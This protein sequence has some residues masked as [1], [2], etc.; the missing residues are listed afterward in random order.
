M[1]RNGFFSL[2]GTAI[3][4][5]SRRMK[6][7]SSL[8]LIGPPKM[9]APAWS[10]MVGGSG[11]PKRGRRTSS[12]WPS[13]CKAWPTRP[14]VECSW[15]R[16]I[17]IGCPMIAQVSRKR[18]AIAPARIP[19]AFAGIQAAPAMLLRVARGPARRYA[20]I[21]DA[22]Q[23]RMRRKAHER[24]REPVAEAGDDHAAAAHEAVDS[25]RAP[26]ARPAASGIR[27]APPVAQPGARLEFGR[28]RPRTERGHPMPRPA[29]SRCSASLNDST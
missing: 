13:C 22:Q 27:S 25:R 28:H 26:R 10:R 6:S 12:G 14:G 29:S 19:I 20:P 4:S 23:Q 7:S 1:P 24:R 9:T 2:S 5:I 18:I 8:A 16:T 11:S 15:C 3:Q 21:D 17:R